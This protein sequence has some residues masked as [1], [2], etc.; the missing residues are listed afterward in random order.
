MGKVTFTNFNKIL[1]SVKNEKMSNTSNFSAL[2]KMKKNMETSPQN[3]PGK[4]DQQTP[5]KDQIYMH[6]RRC[7]SVLHRRRK[8]V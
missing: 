8:S 1:K 5:P 6:Q 3:Q 4:S 2:S 7:S